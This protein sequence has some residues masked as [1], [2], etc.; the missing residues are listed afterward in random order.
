MEAV[1]EECKAKQKIGI[2]WNKVNLDEV[3]KQNKIRAKRKQRILRIQDK[4]MKACTVIVVV[5]FAIIAYGVFF[6]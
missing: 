2:F 6:T 3:L 5:N 1:C 4:I